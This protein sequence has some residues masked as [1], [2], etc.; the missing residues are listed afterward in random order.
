MT[1]RVIKDLE[2]VTHRFE[3][4]TFHNTRC[5]RTAW[6][7]V[8]GLEMRVLNK[9]AHVLGEGVVDCMSCLVGPT[10]LERSDLAT[11]PEIEVLI[12]LLDEHGGRMCE[13]RLVLL[14]WGHCQETLVY[15]DTPIGARIG[16][17]AYLT[18]DGDEIS[19]SPLSDGQSQH[20]VRRTEDDTLHLTVTVG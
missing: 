14:K 6:T 13:P 17:V 19:R 12:V 18:E 3:G 10:R 16:S 11:S 7:R 5:G 8:A 20:F 2:D 9:D 15:D 4:G 1:R